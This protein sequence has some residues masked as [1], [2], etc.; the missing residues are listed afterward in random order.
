MD[1]THPVGTEKISSGYG[2]RKDPFTNKIS[3]HKGLD[4]SVQ[5]NTLVYPSLPGTILNTDY[6]P[7]YGN[8]IL[9]DHGNGIKTLYAHLNS[10]L[11]KVGDKVTQDNPIAYSGNSG[12]STAP[13][14]HFSIFINDK[15]VNPSKFLKLPFEPKKTPNNIFPLI[16]VS[17]LFFFLYK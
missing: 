4:Y 11:S 7:S 6:E 12:R 1:F 16:I 15:T 17:G 10:F 8:R 5:L 14:L 9:I 13:H 2:Y 3:F